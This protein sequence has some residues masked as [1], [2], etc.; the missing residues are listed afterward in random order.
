MAPERF[1]DEQKRLIL[2]ALKN[3]T[4][5]QE[6][7]E[8]YGCQRRTIGRLVKDRGESRKYEDWPDEAV[9]TLREQLAIE[10]R[11][12]TAQIATIINELHGTK[13]TRGAITGKTKRLGLSS[14]LA[15][16]RPKKPGPRTS[17]LNK[18]PFTPVKPRIVAAPSIIVSLVDNADSLEVT[19][20]ELEDGM[21][22]WMTGHST[23]CGHSTPGRRVPYCRKHHNAG[24]EPAKYPVGM[25]RSS[26]R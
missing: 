19:M 17:H 22:K 9:A 12:T 14:N 5:Q 1:N 16:G 8:L 10:P 24:T 26:S 7:A 11:H 2:I 21:C 4:P 20:L 6:L 13:F 18:L 23:Y 25:W 3:G 15:K